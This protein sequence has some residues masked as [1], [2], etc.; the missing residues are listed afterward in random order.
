[1]QSMCVARV[2]A[3]IR[4]VESFS[5]F[6]LYQASNTWRFRKVKNLL[7]GK[8]FG[9]KKPKFFGLKKLV[10]KKVC[11]GRLSNVVVKVKVKIKVKLLQDSL[12]VADVADL[13]VTCLKESVPWF[14]E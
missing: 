11:I 8:Y 10:R 7:E 13:V 2:M 6:E 5:F 14:G 3:R 4:K 9:K 12:Y 1:M